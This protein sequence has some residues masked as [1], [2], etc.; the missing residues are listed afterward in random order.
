MKN[1]NL[2]LG[3]AIIAALITRAM[4]IINASSL[5]MDSFGINIVG[6]PASFITSVKTAKIVG[7]LWIL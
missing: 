7:V 5:F 3:T 6:S 4:L 2:K 1:I